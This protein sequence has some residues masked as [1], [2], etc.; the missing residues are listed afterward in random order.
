[1]KS[2]VD[3]HRGGVEVSSELG[4]GTT[5]VVTLPA[6][7][8]HDPASIRRRSERRRPLADRGNVVD[9]SPTARPSLNGEASG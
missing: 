5:F 3:M 9:S 6:D 1:V 2:I 7:P 8:R 4:V